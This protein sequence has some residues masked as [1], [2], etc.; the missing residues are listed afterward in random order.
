MRSAP[1]MAAIEI[2]TTPPSA[3]IVRS[4]E[5]VSNVHS[6]SALLTARSTLENGDTTYHFE[7]AT[8]AEYEAG[9]TYGNSA[10]M[11]D[12]ELAAGTDTRRGQRAARQPDAGRPP[13]TGG[14]SPA[15]WAGPPTGPITPS[16]LSPSS[17]CSKTPAPT[18]TCASRPAR[19]SCWTAAP[20][21]S[22]P[23]PTPAAM[24]SSP[25][26]SPARLPTPDYPE[27]ESPSRVLYAVHDGGIPGTNHPTNSGPDPYV[28]TRGEERLVD[29]I[30][31]RPRQQPLLRRTLLLD[32]LRCRREPRHLRLRRRRRLLALLCR[33]LHR[34]PGP[35]R[36]T[37]NCP[38]HEPARSTPAPRPRPTATSPRT[39]PPTANT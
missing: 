30:R 28:A 20:M 34:D 1:T 25:I 12:G 19:R 10:P 5:S 18:P 36:Q 7:Y 13:I 6:E 37:A 29:R 17:L 23:P 4:G 39:S 21:S 9:E 22:S 31:R 14:S 27:A 35:P 38:G 3:P 16:R 32:P 26:W 33:R 11:P 24:T 8:E 2:L 15:T